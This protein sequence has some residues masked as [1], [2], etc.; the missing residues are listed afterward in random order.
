MRNI[1]KYLLTY[2]LLGW[3]ALETL[4]A[5]TSVGG[6]FIVALGIHSARVVLTLVQRTTV[7]VGIASGS[8]RTFTHVTSVLVDTSGSRSTGIAQTF[9]EVNTLG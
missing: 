2:A 5:F 4:R 8:R 9:I 3:I 6:S 1:Y 7:S